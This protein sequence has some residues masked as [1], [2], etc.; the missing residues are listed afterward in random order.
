MVWKLSIISAPCMTRIHMCL[1]M[2]MSLFALGEWP[3]SRYDY[4]RLQTEQT[5]SRSI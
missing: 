5:I 1:V 3:V 2:R 4:V